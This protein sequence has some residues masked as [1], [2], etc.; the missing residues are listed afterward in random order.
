PNAQRPRPN[1]QHAVLHRGHPPLQR[2]EALLAG[3]E[4]VELTFQ[5]GALWALLAEVQEQPLVPLLR[6]QVLTDGGQVEDGDAYPLLPQPGGGADH[7]GTLPH[8][9]RGEHVAVLAAQQSLVEL[10][11]RAPLYVAGSVAGQRAAGDEERG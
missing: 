3:P 2:A 11:V 4:V 1:T 10:A 9:P 6:G 5:A 7:E 8:L